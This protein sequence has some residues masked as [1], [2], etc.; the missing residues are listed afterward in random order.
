MH[1]LP[2]PNQLLVGALAFLRIGGILFGLPIFGDAP[3]P[4]RARILTALALTIGI[5][6]LIPPGWAPILAVDPLV[7]GAYIV[8]E[9]LIGLTIGF[10][11]RV[12]FDGLMMAASVV[13]FQM[14]FGTA[15][16]FLPDYSERMDGFSAFHRMIVMLI[17]LTLGL[18]QIFIRA[19]ADTFE[20]IPGGA[21]R[22][23][24]PLGVM[25]INLTGGMLSVAIQLA[26]PVL[27]ALLFT[28]AALG[29]I[30]R[31]V[32]NMNAFIMSFPASFC[33]GLVIYIATLPFFPG[34]MTEHFA[35]LHEQITG[36]IRALA[37]GT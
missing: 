36:V 17:F 3:T 18:H 19:I 15:N 4:A 9:L 30:A 5:Y 12:A 28:M 16:L 22:L 23:T 24:A 1:G 21:A 13:S 7:I 37:G 10:F 34:W 27:V 20:L 2:D 31:T 32:P 6:P 35:S 26:A 33:V 11:A 8:K 14:G 29:L 25:F